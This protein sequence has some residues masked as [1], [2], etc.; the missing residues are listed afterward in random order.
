MNRRVLII[1]EYGICNGGENSLLSIIPLLNTKGWEFEAAVPVPS[2]FAMRLRNVCTNVHSFS[3]LS[4]DGSRLSQQEI[5]DA[6]RELM[7]SVRPDLVH[8]NS[9]ST[10]RLAGPVTKELGIASL[11]HIRDIVKLSKKA[12][13]D[14]GCLDRTIAVS[15]ATRGWH[16]EQGFDAAQTHVVYNGVDIERFFPPDENGPTNP[17]DALALE[18]KLP[19]GTQVILYVGQI[20]MRKGIDVLISAFFKIANQ[21]SNSHLLIVGERNSTKQEAI[22]YEKRLREEVLDSEF[23]NRIHWLGRRNDVP[24]L[25]KAASL[26]LHPARQEPLGRVLLESC[27]AGLV[28]VTTNVGGSSEILASQELGQLLVEKDD[29]DEMAR[30]ALMLLRD[31]EKRVELS[32][33]CRINAEERFH[34]ELCAEAIHRHYSELTR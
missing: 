7:E 9:L 33:L 29:A 1:G 6:L 14:I 19:A 23:R 22:E 15:H 12:V 21:N 18:Q 24:M 16:I 25:M 31:R 30:I 3:T 17:H 28:P 2:P 4:V 32:K 34:V 20:G 11:G 13:A 27:A 5:R 26:L 8:C 10:S